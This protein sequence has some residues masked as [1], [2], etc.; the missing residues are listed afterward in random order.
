LIRLVDSV[1][2]IRSLVREAVVS[3]EDVHP[4]VR[5]AFLGLDVAFV[6]GSVAVNFDT[7]VHNAVT[8]AAYPN[9][10]T[11]LAKGIDR[12]GAYNNNCV[13]FAFAK[14]RDLAVD[15]WSNEYFGRDGEDLIVEIK[16]GVFERF[17]AFA[18]DEQV[19]ESVFPFFL[20]VLRAEVSFVLGA[21]Q[22][23]DQNVRVGV[24]MCDSDCV[25]FWLA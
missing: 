12:A 6:H 2:A 23:I 19:N 7:A 15:N 8:R 13:D 21:A 20:E 5:W 4:H 10:A 11:F 24:Q 9:V 16:P 3:F 18:S 1:E 14:W 17:G 25:S 22:N